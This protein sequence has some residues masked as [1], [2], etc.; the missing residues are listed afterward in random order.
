VPSQSQ[1]PHIASLSMFSSRTRPRQGSASPAPKHP[2]H[3]SADSNRLAGIQERNREGRLLDE[4]IK[5]SLRRSWEEWKVGV[6]K[7][8]RWYV[9]EPGIDRIPLP[10]ALASERSSV[11]IVGAR[12][13]LTGT[14]AKRLLV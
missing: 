8:R 1:T 2:Q 6:N 5:T 12:S 11:F 13:S 10:L 3:T 9:P 7:L 4:W 14:E